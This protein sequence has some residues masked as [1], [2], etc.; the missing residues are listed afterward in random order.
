M[1]ILII[2]AKGMLGSMVGEVFKEYEPTLW[3]RHEIDITDADLSELKIS[4]EKPDVIIN[5]AAYTDVDG[6]EED[7]ET[8]LDINGQGVKNLAEIAK[9]LDAILVHYS[10]D[11]VFPGD[12]E[13]GYGEEDVPGPAVNVYGASKLVGEKALY[14]V[15]PNFYL[16]RIAWLY[17]PN[18]KN[19]VDTMLQLAQ[20]RESLSVVNDQHGSPTFT[21]DVAMATKKLLEENKPYGVYHTV[22]NGVTTWYDFAQKIFALFH[23]N[24][25]VSPVP[26]DE[27][28]RP[29]KRPTYSVLKDTKGM[30]MRDWED[31]LDDYLKNYYGR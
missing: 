30:N 25:E 2:G 31:A 28:P 15:Q 12:K 7:K 14:E 3:D 19:F 10:T 17:G 18:G 20:T 11:Y 4:A 16:L 23:K 13:E 27:F 21:K 22:N 6:A 5:A 9:S 26:S 8:A 1:K 29:A 24:I